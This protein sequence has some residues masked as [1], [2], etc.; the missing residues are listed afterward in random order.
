MCAQKKAGQTKV[1]VLLERL[2]QLTSAVQKLTEIVSLNQRVAS[3]PHNKD[4]NIE[5]FDDL[6]AASIGSG[7]LDR[8]LADRYGLRARPA[9]R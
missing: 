6:V 4:C 1:D 5:T 8:Q 3:V 2:D 9:L 7:S